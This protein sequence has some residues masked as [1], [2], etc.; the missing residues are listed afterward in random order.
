M[1][2]GNVCR[3]QEKG[4]ITMSDYDTIIIG[5]GP[6][7]MS[8]G[9]ALAAKQ[10]VLIV[11][12][13][14]WGGTCPNRGC[15]PK[16]LLYGVVA[17]YLQAQRFVGSGMPEIGALN[18]ADLHAFERS[19]VSG[20]SDGMKQSM[21]GSGVT[22]VQGTARFVDDHTIAVGDDTYTADNIVIATG[23]APNVLPILGHELLKTSDDFLALDEMPKSVAFI[24]AGYITA[25][26][27]TVAAA[28]GAKVHIIQVDESFLTMMPKADSQDLI[29][30][31]E[32]RGV[33]F[34]W[35]T[36][37]ETVEK[38]DAGVV[39]HTNNGDINVGLGI[40]A[41]GRH[42]EID[43][44]DLDKAG[45]TSDRHGVP[46]DDHMRTNVP[47]ILAIGDV[48]SQRR[49]KLTPVAQFEGSYV[50]NFI[51]GDDAP[52]RYSAIPTVAYSFPQIAQ[53]GLNADAADPDKYT[54]T[55]MPVGGW[56]NYMHMKDD[57]AAVTTV[58]DKSTGTL[59]GA[60][61]F[62]ADTEA[63]INSFGR[64]ID[65]KATHADIAAAITAYPTTESDLPYY[66]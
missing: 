54:V 50:A 39:L 25:E 13:D 38:T 57:T 46:V 52:I 16:K 15:D 58:V 59:V 17:N 19:Y 66:L 8:I 12:K 21:A 6:G 42:P 3:V 10:R 43:A 65:R 36:T 41:I 49:P 2:D 33:E 48:V 45:V 23:A 22:T 4:R 60:S 27:A 40:M 9:P 32:A 18:W 56:Y 11:E 51:L 26:L 35:N 31:L 62:A 7:A 30:A 28:A 34:H 47:H 61:V 44:L 63:L 53:V 55:R 20:V 29:K 24:G 37:T 1:R 5:S 64:L 14:A